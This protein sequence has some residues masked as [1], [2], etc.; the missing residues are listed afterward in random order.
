V[1]P[2]YLGGLANL[3][4]FGIAIILEAGTVYESINQSTDLLMLATACK[5]LKEFVTEELGFPIAFAKLRRQL[6]L[7]G[8]RRLQLA[9]RA[10]V[11]SVSR[12]ETSS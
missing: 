11:N 6:R 5:S 2:T 10:R 3:R 9:K 4:F 12:I 7:A 8:Y 1:S